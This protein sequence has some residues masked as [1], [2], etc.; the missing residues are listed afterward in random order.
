MDPSQGRLHLERVTSDHQWPWPHLYLSCPPKTVWE[1]E[2]GIKDSPRVKVRWKWENGLKGFRVWKSGSG[3]GQK[4]NRDKKKTE[5]GQQEAEIIIP[6]RIHNQMKKT[7]GL[8]T[9]RSQYQSRC[10][11]TA[12]TQQR[13]RVIILR[14][15]PVHC[16]SWT[17]SDIP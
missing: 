8:F 5:T 12:M 4:K 2:M 1:R 7:P 17:G 14:S 11:H 15:A 3:K 10:F 6:L 16:E 9:Q 13:N